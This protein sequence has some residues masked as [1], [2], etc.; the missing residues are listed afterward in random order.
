MSFIY[1]MSD[2]HGCLTEFEEA[3]DLWELGTDDYT[4]TEKYPAETGHFTWT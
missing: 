3:E 2:I 1:A 4:F